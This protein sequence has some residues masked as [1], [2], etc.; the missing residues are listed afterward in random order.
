MLAI[1]WAFVA[2]GSN[3]GD[4]DHHLA[5]GREALAALPNTSLVAVTPV[6][7]TEPIGPPGQGSYLNQMALLRTTLEPRVLLDR[8]LAIERVEGRVRRVRW[9][10]RT[11]DLDIVR[12]GDR[13]VSEP[14]LTIPHPELPNRSF[15]HRELDVLLHHAR[16][17]E[18]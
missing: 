12:Y 2:L 6:E 4:R 10:P 3:S 7:E 11:L 9:G 16:E 5:R 17:D 1:E 8:C 18:Q 13:E 15:W 14:G